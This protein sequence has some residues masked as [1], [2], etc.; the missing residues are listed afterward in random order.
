M[1]HRGRSLA[2]AVRLVDRFTGD[3]PSDGVTIE[4]AS[5]DASPVKNP[6]GYHLFFDLE[7]SEVTLVVDGGDR[8]VD[9]R[10]HVVLEPEDAAAGEAPDEGEPPTHVVTD[11]SD[12]LVVS[13][14]PTPA[15][16]FPTTST[17][18]RGHVRDGAGE[19]V[20][21]ASVSLRAFDPVVETTGTGEYALW[22]PASA[23]HVVRRNG[24][25]VVVVDGLTGNGRRA[26][27]GGGGTNPT[28]VV[29]HPDYADVAERI[30]VTAGTRT[31]CHVT[32]E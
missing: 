21:G 24:G 17:V 15:Y 22:V 16:A 29:S 8:Y 3:E 14:S 23:E 27:D 26:A 18:L 25:N 28:L 2:F 10:C 9:H 31:V 4:A 6:S 13:L 19:P 32:L 5:I 1:E 7:P 12:P 20:E 30:E 11:P